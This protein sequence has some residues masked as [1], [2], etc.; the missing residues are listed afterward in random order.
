MRMKLKKKCH[1]SGSKVTF[2]G[3]GDGIR[4]YDV[5]CE[6]EGHTH[7]DE[8]VTLPEDDDR[9]EV[10]SKCHKEENSNKVVFDCET[11]KGVVIIEEDEEKQK[12]SDALIEQIKKDMEEGDTTVLDMILMKHSTKY[13]KGCLPEEDA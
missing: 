8:M 13:L 11:P 1:I 2:E 3:K 9:M 10:C 12:I 6:C 5:C 7:P 4:E